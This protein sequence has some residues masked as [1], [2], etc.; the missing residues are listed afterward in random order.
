MAQVLSS[1]SC[2]RHPKVIMEKN[3]I[4]SYFCPE[5]DHDWLIHPYRNRK[6]GYEQKPRLKMVKGKL[7]RG[8][9]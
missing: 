2:P 4:D 5:C 3:Y 8:R 9:L 1:Y 6:R 7:T